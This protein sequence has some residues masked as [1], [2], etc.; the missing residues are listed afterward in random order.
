M[1]VPLE[2]YLVAAAMLFGVGLYTI[3]AQRSVVM[4]LMGIELLLNAIGLNAV[5][6]WRF[7]APTDYSGQ[8]FTIIVV[9]IG[10]VEMTIG[11]GIMMLVYRVRHT[12]QVDSFQALKG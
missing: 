10:A 11:L 4:M 12:V 5:A 2:A 6:F 7:V 9:T 8:L 1:T 3:L